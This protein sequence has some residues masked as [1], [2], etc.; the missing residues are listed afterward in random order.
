MAY[1]FGNSINDRSMINPLNTAPDNTPIY[2]YEIISALAFRILPGL[3]LLVCMM[4]WLS[5]TTR[6][7]YF[8]AF[9]IFGSLG[10]FCLAIYFANGPISLLGFLIAFIISPILLIRNWITLRISAR[11]STCHRI[12]Q[13]ASVFPILNLIFFITWTPSA[14]RQPA[15]QDGGGNSAALRASP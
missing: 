14:E 9:C 6:P 8:A 15:E 10:S 2:V 4:M 13:W 7:P 12:I 3:F 11:R 1:T 5:R